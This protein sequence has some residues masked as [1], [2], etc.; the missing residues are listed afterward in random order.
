[1]VLLYPVQICSIFTE[2]D[3]NM[4]GPLWGL[5]KHMDAC[6]GSRPEPNDL[7][8]SKIVYGSSQLPDA[9]FEFTYN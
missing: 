9:Y 3:T 1:M 7:S 6:I 5:Q 2:L 4:V 8:I